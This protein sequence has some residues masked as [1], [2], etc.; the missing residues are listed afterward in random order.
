ME[1]IRYINGEPVN[2]IP[3]MKV[4]NEGLLQII[5]DLRM[6]ASQ[7]QQSSDPNNSPATDP[8]KK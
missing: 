5:K 2:A 7:E 1:V 8:G 4:I 3:P 6:K